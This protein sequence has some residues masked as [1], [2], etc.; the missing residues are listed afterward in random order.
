MSEDAVF[1]RGAGQQATG[2]DKTHQST[3]TKPTTNP[4]TGT[5]PQPKPPKESTG[6]MQK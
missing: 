1:G 4:K 6:N 5:M 2:L 3:L